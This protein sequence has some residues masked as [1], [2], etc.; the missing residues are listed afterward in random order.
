MRS[1]RFPVPAF[2]GLLAVVLLSPAM[3]GAQE[4]TPFP[5]GGDLQV[6]EHRDVRFEGGWPLG[7][8]PDGRWLA[9]WRF[10]EDDERD[11]ICA[12]DAVTLAEYRCVTMEARSPDTVN[13]APDGTRL[14]FTESLQFGE[15]PDIWVFDVAA[16]TVTNLTDDGT[17]RLFGG[18]K[19]GDIDLAPA[20]S[21]DGT[22]LVFARNVGR[23]T[24]LYRVPVAGG[25]VERI[26]SVSRAEPYAVW[27]GVQ[28]PVDDTILVSVDPERADEEAGLWAIDLAG[29]EPRRIVAPDRVA[30]APILVA[31]SARNQ[32]LLFYPDAMST[33]GLAVPPFAI[34]DLEHGKVEPIVPEVSG[35]AGTATYRRVTA[36]AF[37][38]DGTRL[39]LSYGGVAG[40]GVAVRDLATGEEQ[41]LPLPSLE[42][43]LITHFT[44]TG[45]TW[46]T[47]G[48]V[49][50][51]GPARGGVLLRLVST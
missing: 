14:A 2:A 42:W 20:W 34:A 47:N 4:A 46:A 25:E 8:A 18:D 22:E 24:T 19:R 43:P 17:D 51:V 16:G 32:A 27:A 30:G 37:S 28:W 3:A 29:G 15:D 38:P 44:G 13:W 1:L 26:A 10:G 12:Y 6:V 49:Y 11:A 40:P 39:F 21:P 5:P 31:V 23:G 50:A 9:V 35:P 48:L 36:A 7:L 41:P 33:Y 45:M